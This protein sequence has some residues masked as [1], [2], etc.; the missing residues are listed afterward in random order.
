VKALVYHGPNEMRWQDWPDP[1]PGPG[2][3]VVAVRAVGICGSDLHGYTGESGRRKPPMVMGHEASGEIIAVGSGVAES[4]MGEQVLVQP[5]LTCGTCHECRTG[6]AHRCH[7]R[8]FLGGNANGA[9]AERFVAPLSNLLPL[10]DGVSPVLGT[11]VEPLA[12]GLHA[13]RQAGDLT[14]RS[15]LIAG[16]G[17][18]GLCTMIAA[19]RFGARAVV[20]TDVIPARRNVAIALGAD[21]ALDPGEGDWQQELAQMI[22]AQEVDVA[23]DAVGI[24][25]TFEQ[26]IKAVCLGGTVIAIG[27]WRTVP[28]DLSYLVAHEIHLIGSFNYTPE[29]F[30]EARLWL[31]EGR[32]D[33][34]PMMIDS[35]PLAEGAAVFSELVGNRPKA[36]KV[37]LTSDG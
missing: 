25:P 33:L 36:I 4:V 30:D 11:L 10:P 28:I 5:I 1:K 29:E 13:A 16:S 35:R 37:V 22:G 24:S 26:A 18:I 34:S 17:P 14:R 19:R 27:G 23:F 2:E 20:M 9:M 32:F 12:V 21:A 8:R 3:A 7:H 31:G 15:V 6:H